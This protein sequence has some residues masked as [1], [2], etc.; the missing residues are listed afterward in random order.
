MNTRTSEHGIQE[1]STHEQDFSL[2]AEEVRNVSKRRHI[3]NASIQNKCIDMGIFMSSSTKAA[4]HLGPNY[5]ANS[6]IYK[7]TKFE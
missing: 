4:I 6:E 5:L 3:L 2:F 7:N 1:P